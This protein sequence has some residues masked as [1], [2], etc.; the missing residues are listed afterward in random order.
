VVDPQRPP[1]SLPPRRAAFLRLRHTPPGRRPTAYFGCGCRGRSPSGAPTPTHPVPASSSSVVHV[2]VRCGRLAQAHTKTKA[3]RGCRRSHKRLPPPSA[4]AAAAAAAPPRSCCSAA[5]SR[6][7]HPRR[8]ASCQLC[9]PIL[10]FAASV[11]HFINT[12][13]K[14]PNESP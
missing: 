10:H 6:I 12:H 3:A 1:E 5:A 11:E 9:S 7:D 14:T 8:L 4:P 13:C 2:C